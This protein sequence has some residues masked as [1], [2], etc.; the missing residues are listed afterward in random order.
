[1]KLLKKREKE[2]YFWGTDLELLP[3]QK[4]VHS[5]LLLV[6]YFSLSFLSINTYFVTYYSKDEKNQVCWNFSYVYNQTLSLSLLLLYRV[7]LGF[8]PTSCEEYLDVC[9]SNQM[10]FNMN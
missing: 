1:M 9:A 10:I 6:N 8:T 2:T 3:R 4:S 5:A 7:C